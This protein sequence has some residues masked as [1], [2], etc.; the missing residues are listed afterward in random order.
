MQREKT[1]EPNY[2]VLSNNPVTETPTR[3]FRG[4]SVPARSESGTPTPIPSLS[5]GQR[6]Q[7]RLGEVASPLKNEPRRVRKPTPK[8]MAT[9]TESVTIISPETHRQGPA[10]T[11]RDSASAAGGDDGNPPSPR[12]DGSRTPDGG[13]GGGG[14]GDPE[15]GDGGGD[16]DSSDD[17]SDRDSD[18]GDSRR[19]PG[20]NISLGDLTNAL[21]EAFRSEKDP[22]EKDVKVRNPDP[23]DGV[24][25]KGIR[26]FLFQNQLVFNAKPRTFKSDSAK[27]NYALSFLRGT[28]L[29]HFEPYVMDMS[30][31][32]A[33]PQDFLVYWSEF[34]EELL[35]QFGVT[36]EE[37]D[38][39]DALENL[40]MAS[41]GHAVRFFVLFQKYKT[42]TSWNDRAYYRVAYKNLPRRIK[43]RLNELYPKPKTYKALR[44]AA[45]QIDARYW[46]YKR[47]LDRESGGVKSTNNSSS[48]KSSTNPGTSGSAGSSN[49]KSKSSSSSG[50]SVSKTK[51]SN[52][53]SSSSSG[54]SANTS[55]QAKHIG[56]DGH[57][58]QA[59]RDRRMK[60]G[61]CLICGNKGHMAKECPKS[62]FN[63][64]GAPAATNNSGSSKT[65]AKARA[66]KAEEAPESKN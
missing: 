66:T 46:E 60:Q 24:D 48:N 29:D 42:R 23:Y 58:T 8:T 4:S 51:S 62:K 63:A 61:L 1:P 54:T 64:S 59:E 28:A 18:R 21:R 50:G 52:T 45:L 9:I 43:D 12:D 53:G 35:N 7:A 37:E 15:P 11:T 57:L 65:Q 25:P 33:E 19:G 5:R 30:T 36:N 20:N 6:Y 10:D 27:I 32:E 3:R 55:T 49:N 16:G 22:A 13:H 2:F 41:T 14:G 31:G 34:A 44:S 56:S 17:D 38:A 26:T 40:K 47:E 39:E